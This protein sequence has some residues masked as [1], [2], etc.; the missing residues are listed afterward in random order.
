MSGTEAYLW[1][2][3]GAVVA[4]F[5]GDILM[6]VFSGPGKTAQILPFI[7]GV[8]VVVWIGLIIEQ[9]EKVR[10]EGVQ[11]IATRLDKITSLLT[12]QGESLKLIERL[13]REA[14]IR[15]M[16]EDIEGKASL[17]VAIEDN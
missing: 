16:A 12:Q 11:A 15:R 8:L 3:K 14:E 2:I 4:L 7:F 10:T 17:Q 5:V 9:L 1:T 13:A 6:R